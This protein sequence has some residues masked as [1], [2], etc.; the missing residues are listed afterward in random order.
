MK[1]EYCKTNVISKQLQ[2]GSKHDA[3]L[4]LIVKHRFGYNFTIW[5]HIHTASLWMHSN[6]TCWYS[7]QEIL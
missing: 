2:N 7:S 4:V 6:T 5:P 3:C 1:S